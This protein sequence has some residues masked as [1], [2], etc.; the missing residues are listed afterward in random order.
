M[1]TV[2]QNGVFCILFALGLLAGGIG[3]A[4]NAANVASDY[5]DAQCAELRDRF[6][7]NSLFA[8]T[9]DNFE[10]LRNSQAA[11]AVSAYLA[12][13]LC[14]LYDSHLNYVHILKFNS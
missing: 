6:P 12:I 7:D 5:D 10:R 13:I 11:G 8:E 9:C 3:S 4:A 1:I 14:Y 2:L